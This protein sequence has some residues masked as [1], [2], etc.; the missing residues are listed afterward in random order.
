MASY[1][2]H[3]PLHLQQRVVEP[4]IDMFSR[5]QK[6]TSR[7][8]AQE[9]DNFWKSLHEMRC[10][11]WLEE[12]FVRGVFACPYVPSIRVTDRRMPQSVNRSLT[13]RLNGYTK[14]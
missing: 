13:E 2:N 1:D 3:A 9:S 12:I 5:Q 10:V 6:P 11:H 4:N 7:G 14:F 8:E